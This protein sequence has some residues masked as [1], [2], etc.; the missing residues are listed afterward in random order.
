MI[1]VTTI[2]K[3]AKFKKKK[4]INIQNMCSNLYNLKIMTLQCINLQ[5][6][7]WLKTL[8]QAFKDLYVGLY[9][10]EDWMKG[11][12]QMKLSLTFPSKSKPSKVFR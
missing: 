1:Y 2:K 6:I 12:N 9:Y 7:N 3:G 11:M 8:L 5:L 10:F 4:K